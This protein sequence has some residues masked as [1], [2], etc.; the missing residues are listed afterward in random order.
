MVIADT[1]V[2]I[3]FFK[4]KEPIS[5]HMRGMLEIQ[6]VLAVECIFAEL[7][8]GATNVRERE[9]INK[10]WHYLPKAQEKGI[11]IEAGTFSGENNLTSKGIG[12]ID[13]V[14]IIASRKTGARLWTL[15]KK[16]QAYLEKI[17]PE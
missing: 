2:W 11:W 15:D 13:S 6:E 9:I 12:L 17:Q 4:G 1:S 3:E 8:Q 10:Y 16:L 7:L 5:K 14:L